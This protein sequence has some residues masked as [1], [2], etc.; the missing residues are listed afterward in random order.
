[1]KISCPDCDGIGFIYEYDEDGHA[2]DEDN[3][4][5]CKATGVVEEDD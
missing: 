2:V 1:M 5:T 3:C 4:H